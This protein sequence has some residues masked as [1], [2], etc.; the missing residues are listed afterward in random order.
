MPV[1][2]F[3]HWSVVLAQAIHRR[4]VVDLDAFDRG[5]KIAHWGV[6][7]QLNC[8]GV[9]IECG[10][11]TSP[12]E[13]RKIATPAYRQKLAEA[14]ATGIRDYAQIAEGPRPRASAASAASRRTSSPFN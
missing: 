3:D 11:L 9:L 6:L 2:R 14:I 4:F 5:K 12:T 7:R 13:A 8:P 10:F 1:N